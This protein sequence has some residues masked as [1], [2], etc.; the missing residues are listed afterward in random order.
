M[1]VCIK[2]ILSEITYIILFNFER[3]RSPTAD[4]RRQVC[5]QI[6]TDYPFQ[7]D[8]DGGCVSRYII[9]MTINN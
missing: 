5:R 6:I 4:Q 9:N 1:N 7:A 8:V 3:D 2:T